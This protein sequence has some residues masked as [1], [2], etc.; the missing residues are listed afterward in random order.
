MKMAPYGKTDDDSLKSQLDKYEYQIL[1]SMLDK[2]GTST[3]SK[4]KIASLLD[5][6][7]S[8]FYRKLNKYNLSE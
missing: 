8:T 4:E 7:L 1:S 3:E 2:Y 5:I 6:N